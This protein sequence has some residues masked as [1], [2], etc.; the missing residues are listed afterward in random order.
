VTW[1]A[2]ELLAAAE[3]DDLH[4]GDVSDPRIDPNGTPGWGVVNLDLGGVFGERGRWSVGVHN[5]FD[6]AYRRHGTGFDGPGLGL[7]VGLGWGG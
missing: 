6:A 4:P 1:G 7:V 2:L 3:Q 5:L